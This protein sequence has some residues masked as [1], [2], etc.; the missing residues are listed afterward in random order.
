MPLENLQEP[1]RHAAPVE[2][3]GHHGLCRARQALALRGI[4]QQTEALVRERVR[5]VADKDGLSVGVL[6]F[7]QGTAD[8]RDPSR[9]LG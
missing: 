1:A 3:L 8:K 2:V 5:L 9:G 4:I 6:S 7:K